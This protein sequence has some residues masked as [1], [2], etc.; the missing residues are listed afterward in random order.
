MR[1]QLLAVDKWQRGTQTNVHLRSNLTAVS[2]RVGVRPLSRLGPPLQLPI[3][4]LA[5]LV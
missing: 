5:R 3:T 2:K 1:R 4:W